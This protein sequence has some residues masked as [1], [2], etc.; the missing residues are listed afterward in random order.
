MLN[1]E[2]TPVVT[3]NPTDGGAGLGGEVN[4]APGTPDQGDDATAATLRQVTLLL[5][6]LTDKNKELENRMQLNATV[7]NE[8]RARASTRD[9]EMAKMRETIDEL[10]QSFGCVTA[11]ID[12]NARLTKSALEGAARAAVDRPPRLDSSA[13]N[14]DSFPPN[15]QQLGRDPMFHTFR[16]PADSRQ[17][18]HPI[19]PV[20][21]NRLAAP[22][23][24]GADDSDDEED[25]RYYRRGMALPIEQ[26]T[27]FKGRKQDNAQ[28]FLYEINNYFMCAH[29]PKKMKVPTF[30]MW[31][32]GAARD[33]FHNEVNNRGTT[34]W[35]DVEAL[36]K[37]RY[38][39]TDN[40]EESR[41]RLREFKHQLR[42]TAHDYLQQ[43]ELLA[44][45]GY[46]D[47]FDSEGTR[48]SMEHVR[49]THVRD[50]ML[51]GFSSSIVSKMADTKYDT[52][53]NEDLATQINK[54]LMRERSL[55]Q[56]DAPSTAFNEASTRTRRPSGRSTL[57]NEVL[58]DIKGAEASL[59]EK[60][61]LIQELK[62]ANEALQRADQA[63]PAGNQG[64]RPPP[65][66]RTKDKCFVCG[67]PGHYKIECPVWLK[68]KQEAGQRNERYK[69]KS[70]T[71]PVSRERYGRKHLESTRTKIEQ[72][73]AHREA[74]GDTSDK[75]ESQDF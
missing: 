69:N 33:F 25:H 24:R 11:A 46:P 67:E 62:A 23:R 37:K 7:M 9:T 21:H 42:M 12:E 1:E 66:D 36:F 61:L 43:V 35:V 10:C 3:D 4:G 39:D 63:R 8:T 20:T 14:S 55:R 38:I 19:P 29:T 2:E 6:N 18:D 31:L 56:E 49:I 16:E 48:Q 51:R 50:K 54:L 34:S 59:E 60:D 32:D 30:L 74:T 45:K 5:H 73:A 53:D 57:I 58:D 17:G 40:R 72:L 28:A 75:E 44:A 65:R 64:D 52:Y 71:M 26:M 22:G 41:A 68:R 47:Q 15:Q 27:K 13:S 70:S